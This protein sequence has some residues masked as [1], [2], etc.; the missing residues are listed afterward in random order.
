MLHLPHRDGAWDTSRWLD[1]ALN[2]SALEKGIRYAGVV[3]RAV[4]RSAFGDARTAPFAEQEAEGFARNPGS[5]RT[6]QMHDGGLLANCQ[7]L[8][9]RHQR[10]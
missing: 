1:S 3:E 4:T 2:H 9:V 7:L 10:L 6:K 5:I 8:V